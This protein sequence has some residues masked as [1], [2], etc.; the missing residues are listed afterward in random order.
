[1]PETKS[2]KVGLWIVIILGILAIIFIV[3][4]IVKESHQQTVVSHKTM[5]DFEVYRTKSLSDINS[6]LADGHKC[7]YQD[8]VPIL[9]KALIGFAP[10][11]KKIKAWVNQNKKAVKPILWFNSN[12]E[13][14]EEDAEEAIRHEILHLI[15]NKKGEF[16][17]GPDRYTR[18]VG[19]SK[20]PVCRPFGDEVYDSEQLT[21]AIAR[22]FAKVTLAQKE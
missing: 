19:E 20:I 7:I 12:L 3:P 16:I 11:N 4:E 14:C 5:L 8:A 17:C 9:E 18:K 6:H 22:H 21:N 1:M 13:W 15:Q 2:Q 10:R